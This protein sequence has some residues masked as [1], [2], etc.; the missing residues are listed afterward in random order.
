MPMISMEAI[1]RTIH[2]Q[3]A[4]I[5]ELK[6]KIAVLES[7]LQNQKR[8]ELAEELVKLVRD[9]PEKLPNPMVVSTDFH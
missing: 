8:I 5:K 6:Q 2:E 3:D 4:Q 9:Y 1:F 7:L